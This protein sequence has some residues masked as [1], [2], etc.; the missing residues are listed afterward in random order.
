MP[1]QINTPALHMRWSRAPWDESVCGFP[2]LQIDALEIV[3]PSAEL[4]FHVFESERERLGAGLVSC[5]LANDRMRESMLLEEHGF[6][7]IEMMFSPQIELD[8]SDP[9]NVD[10]LLT[11]DRAVADHL[12]ELMTIAGTAFEHERFA[13]DPRLDPTISGRRYQNW[14]ASTLAHPTQQ[15]HVIRENDTIVAFFVSEMLDDATCY[16][17]LTAVAPHM[18]GCGY[19]RRVWRRMLAKATAD[20][21]RRVRTSIAARNHRVLNLYARLGF[22]FPPPTMTLHWT[23]G[24]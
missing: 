17:H 7:F 20:G 23:R 10:D 9:A 12:P 13:L 5:R 6:R 15:L 22:R 2:V 19:G 14:V 11:V 8:A 21:A 1:E 18:Q 16:G 3:C 4:D 24:A